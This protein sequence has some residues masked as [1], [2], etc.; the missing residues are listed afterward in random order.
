MLAAYVLGADNGAA[1]SDTSAT[2]QIPSRYLDRYRY[3]EI[4][5]DDIASSFIR[6]TAIAAMAGGLPTDLISQYEDARG[7]VEF[8]VQQVVDERNALD[9]VTPVNP[10]LPPAA[11]VLS[12]T[13]FGFVPIS[14][15][16]QQ[17]PSQQPNFIPASKI[18]FNYSDG[19]SGGL[20]EA[21]AWGHQ[22]RLMRSRAEA[23]RSGLGEPITTALITIAVIAGVTILGW[24]AFRTWQTYYKTTADVEASRADAQRAAEQARTAD[25]AFTAY[26]KSLRI[27]A[28]KATDASAVAK[29]ISSAGTAAKKAGEGVPKMPE[30]VR[31]GE[32]GRSFVDWALFIA[33][34]VLAVGGAAFVYKRR[35]K[36]KEA[37]QRTGKA[38]EQTKSPTAP[39]S[40]PP[41][42][43]NEW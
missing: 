18:Q 16:T 20:G 40:W 15:L 29:C 13:G 27:C 36:I 14:V 24:M 34:G 25:V 10:Q 7:Y 5:S 12:S 3:L 9:G 4:A 22:Y 1:N 21:L 2:Y 8:P 43:S 33:A 6:L 42:F 39:P 41:D 17:L 37:L 26:E 28:Q 31:P 19:S 11:S 32:V 30:P 35:K 23:Q 38:G